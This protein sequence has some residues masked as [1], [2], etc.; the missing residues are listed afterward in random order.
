MWVVLVLYYRLMFLLNVVF[1]QYRAE[2]CNASF[3]CHRSILKY[4]NKLEMSTVIVYHTQQAV[5]TKCQLLIKVMP[6]FHKLSQ[7]KTTVLLFHS[8]RTKNTFLNSAIKFTKID[9]PLH[10]TVQA[11]YSPASFTARLA[12][13]YRQIQI[14][15]FATVTRTA[16]IKLNLISV[17]EL[18][19]PNPRHVTL[20]S[21]FAAR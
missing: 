19:S 13:P 9:L 17:A 8:L 14:Q 3:G 4:C 2:N 6:D 18:Y 7:S 12:L 15:L 11:W 10:S 16:P 1:M 21:L 5:A 20:Y